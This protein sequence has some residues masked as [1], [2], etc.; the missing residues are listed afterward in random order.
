MDIFAQDKKIQLEEISW[1]Q[2]R[3]STLE[4]SNAC[5][6]IF[7]DIQRMC[8]NQQKN[9][10]QLISDSVTK[11]NTKDRDIRK[12]LIRYKEEVQHTREAD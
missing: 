12:R 1:L 7:N 6:E 2:N 9:T 4:K 11:M 3:I 5:K 8:L 10:K